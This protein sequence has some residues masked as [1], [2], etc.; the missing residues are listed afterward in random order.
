LIFLTAAAVFRFG[1]MEF[2]AVAIASAIIMTI[3][4]IRYGR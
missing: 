2:G 1:V 4:W 3:A